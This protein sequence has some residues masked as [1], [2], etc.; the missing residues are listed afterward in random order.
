MKIDKRRVDGFM[1]KSE[2]T[3]AEIRRVYENGGRRT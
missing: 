3:R 1:S 2:G